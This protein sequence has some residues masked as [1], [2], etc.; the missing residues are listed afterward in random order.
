MFRGIKGPYQGF[1]DQSL[2][3]LPGE[4]RLGGNQGGPKALGCLSALSLE[5]LYRP[6][7]SLRHP[8]EADQT[9]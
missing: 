5:A 8:E 4:R 1:L 9:H 7:V 2:Q 3:V 6:P